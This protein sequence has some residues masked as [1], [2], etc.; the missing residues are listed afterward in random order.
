MSKALLITGA[1]GK[2]GGAVIDALIASPSSNDFT[3]FAVTRNPSSPS[4]TALSQ[5]AQNIKVIQGNLDDCP[6][7]FATANTPIWGVYSVQLPFGGGA[8]PATEERQ[9]KALIDAA[10]ANQVHHFVY[11]S[12]DR[13]GAKSSSDPTNVPHF[14]SKHNIEKHLEEKSAGGSKMSYTILRPVA[15]MEN[16][17]PDFMGKMFATMWKSAL[18]PDRKLQLISTTDI[19]YFTAEAF[20]HPEDS[21][22]KNTSISLAGDDLTFDE[23]SAVFQKVVGTPMPSTFGILGQGLMW[24][25]ADLGIMF[26]WINANG[27]AADIAALKKQDPNLLSFADW[28]KKKESGFVKD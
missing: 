9:G 14:I 10:L 20:S 13:G 23:A 22:Y 28:L 25:M 5:K 4:A 3:I 15:F 24:M 12:V 11:A 26:R 1:T 6:A 19:G 21:Q 2:Q 16:L 8:T 27:Y 17:T 18:A 7:I